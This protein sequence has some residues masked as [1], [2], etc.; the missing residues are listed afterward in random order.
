[1]TPTVTWIKK[2]CWWQ[3]RE[4]KKKWF[5]CSF[6]KTQKHHILVLL[7]HLFNELEK[8]QSH[9]PKQPVMYSYS[10][11]VGAV[12]VRH[13]GFTVQPQQPWLSVPHPAAFSWAVAQGWENSH[14]NLGTYKNLPERFLFA[15]LLSNS[16]FDLLRCLYIFYKISFQATFFFFRPFL[17]YFLLY[18][19]SS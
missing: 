3:E 12:H 15:A 1:M 2:I 19:S 10:P 18:F 8:K 5:P 11:A 7:T 13:F 9:P 16:H 6:G 4:K 14:Q 17:F